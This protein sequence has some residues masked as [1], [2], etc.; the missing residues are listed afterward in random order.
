MK[1]LVQEIFREPQ[2]RVLSGIA[3]GVG[4]CAGL[5]THLL[6]PGVRLPLAVFVGA[7]T[8]G[9]VTQLVLTVLFAVNVAKGLAEDIQE[10]AEKDNA[11][12]N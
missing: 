3:L 6:F 10:D 1:K 11:N 8:C 4:A 2:F 7:I 5:V 9:G 12:R